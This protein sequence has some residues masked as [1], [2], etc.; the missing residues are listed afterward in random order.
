MPLVL[1]G[2]GWGCA[3]CV[4]IETRGIVVDFE[5]E[6]RDPSHTH[7]GFCA[8]QPLGATITTRVDQDSPS[9]R[10]YSTIPD[11]LTADRTAL[12]ALGALRRARLDAPDTESELSEDEDQKPRRKC[13]RE[14]SSITPTLPPV[15][16]TKGIDG[17]WQRL[18]TDAFGEATW[19]RQ[20]ARLK[21]LGLERWRSEWQKYGWEREVLAV[22]AAGDPDRALAIVNQIRACPGTARAVRHGCTRKWRDMDVLLAGAKFKAV[23]ADHELV[24]RSVVDARETWREGVLE[25]VPE[26]LH[27]DADLLRVFTAAQRTHASGSDDFDD[28]GE[29]LEGEGDRWERLGYNARALRPARGPRRPRRPRRPYKHKRKAERKAEREAEREA[30]ASAFIEE[31]KDFF[32]GLVG[33]AR[34]A[35]HQD[36]LFA[37]L[38]GRGHQ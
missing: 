7:C 30:E 2:R 22:A 27:D 1:T 8:F 28:F 13:R 37:G 35:A 29:W 21:E 16:V 4:D 23:A 32:R 18:I 25:R 12:D 15:R 34:S 38:G 9:V 5:D 24:A 36:A 6:A 31:N 10:D 11:T 26:E 19:D 33:E 3:R 14:P 20:K 17:D